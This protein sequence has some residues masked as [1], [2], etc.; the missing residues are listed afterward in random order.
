MR[1]NAEDKFSRQSRGSRVRDCVYILRNISP[2]QD[3]NKKLLS[4]APITLAMIMPCN[5]VGNSISG[6]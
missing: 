4:T 2:V 3:E 1:V 6:I 5:V